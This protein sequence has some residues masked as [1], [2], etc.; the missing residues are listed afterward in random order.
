MFNGF[1]RQSRR[2]VAL[3]SIKQNTQRSEGRSMQSLC[4]IIDTGIEKKKQWKNHKKNS[5]AAM[6]WNKPKFNRWIIRNYEENGIREREK[7]L[8]RDAILVQ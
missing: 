5:L 8:S 4:D 7:K 6:L 3:F 1:M 2:K